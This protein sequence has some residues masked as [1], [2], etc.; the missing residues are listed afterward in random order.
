MYVKKRGELFISWE[1]MSFSCIRLEFI[2]W[3]PKHWPTKKV[4]SDYK[5]NTYSVDLS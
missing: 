4:M 1:E 2:E 3:K 5:D